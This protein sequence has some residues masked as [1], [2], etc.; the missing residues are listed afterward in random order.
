MAKMIACFAWIIYKREVINTRLNAMAVS[1]NQYQGIERTVALLKTV[2]NHPTDGVRLA[3]VADQTQLSPS[4]T[5]RLLSGMVQEGLIEQDPETLRYFPSF[6]L[7]DLG[8]K[9][10][11]RFCLSQIAESSMKDLAQET[12]DTVYLQIRSGDDAVCVNRCEGNYPIKTLTL[13]VGDRRPLGIG[14]G[15]LALLAAL[16]PQECE[17]VMKRNTKRLSNYPQ[18]TSQDIQRFVAEAR[19][20]RFAYNPGLYISGMRAV[21][22]SLSSYSGKLLGSL[23]IAAVD[24]RMDVERCSML[25]SYMNIKANKIIGLIND[26]EN[27]EKFS[28]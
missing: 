26:I 22:I 17:H 15:S 1:P 7:Y 13:S 12:G 25:V 24:S 20:K 8:R 2:A 16:P 23:S 19:E 21:G 27:D 3:D 14:A 5:H 10:S 11:R 18:I 4:T 6:V 9:A 28:I